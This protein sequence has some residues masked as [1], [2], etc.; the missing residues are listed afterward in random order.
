MQ[1]KYLLVV[2]NPPVP[3][4]ERE[5][6]GASSS[7]W[8]AI[9]RCLICCQDKPRFAT[10]GKCGHI[11]VCWICTV[12]LRALLKDNSCPVCKEE[13]SQVALVA[14][15]REASGAHTSSALMDP[16]LGIIYDNEEIRWE[17]ERLF[18]YIC[19]MH[20][21]GQLARSF[22][23]LKELERHLLEEH[24]RQF[25]PT[26]LR[27]RQVF[28]HEQLLYVSDDLSR[29][30][31]EGDAAVL[32]GGVLPPS[33]AHADCKFCRKSIYSQEDLL[34]HMYR[35]H[36]LC[37]LCE[38]SGR[39]WEFYND[40]G[41][42]SLHYQESHYVCPHEDCKRG[43]HYLVAYCTEEELRMH[44][45]SEHCAVDA[46]PGTKG[47]KQGLRLTLQFG[48]SSYRDEQ[49]RRRPAG[50]SAPS[51]AR[52]D[53]DAV[54]IHFRRPQGQVPKG[55]SG[56]WDDWSAVLGAGS[57]DKEDRD[58]DRYP[59]RPLPKAR[60]RV[61][62]PRRSPQEL[63]SGRQKGQA[64]SSSSTAP[65]PRSEP[66]PPCPDSPAVL[67]ER[68]LAQLL[69]VALGHI[70]R[71][72]IDSA[73]ALDQAEYRERNRRF[74][75]DLQE[76]LG[77][78]QLTVFK[79]SSGA[80]RQSL[81]ASGS[82]KEGDYAV[83]T[84]AKQVLEVFATASGAVGEEAAGRLL[85]DLVLLLPDKGP[86]HLIYAALQKLKERKE[87]YITSETRKRASTA[88]QPS[89]I[90]RT[91]S[92]SSVSRTDESLGSCSPN[93]TSA[94][95]TEAVE[96]IP[97][98]A[99]FRRSQGGAEPQLSFLQALNAVLAAVSDGREDRPPASV[100]GSILAAKVREL[101]QIQAESLQQIH[102][103]FADAGG[104]KLDLEPMERLLALR[105]MLALKLQA[106]AQ[107]KS[108]QG[109]HPPERSWREWKVAASAAISALGT[110]ERRCVQTYV[111]F[112]L[113][114]IAEGAVQK[115]A[116]VR[117]ASGAWTTD[118]GPGSVPEAFDFPA[119][120][121]APPPPVTSPVASSIPEAKRK[122]RGRQVLQAWG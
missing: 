23:T 41:S 100:K 24:G 1:M 118:R 4:C 70:G 63:Q 28:L 87:A 122:G 39:K 97:C 6:L 106:K 5:A 40:Y 27:G 16:K 22:R 29:H 80:F 15:P 50:G 90:T 85:C 26:C 103:H 36:S 77:E 47:K 110:E 102:Q 68:A 104:D 30:H 43:V 33:A 54:H 107:P 38:R 89:Q 71:A 88:G 108:P 46:K 21:C 34:E 119:L 93:S 14:D 84:Y 56:A 53:A 91:R 72:G 109:H 10:R 2:R 95:L 17:V 101:D 11:E 98:A 25:C 35:Q 73:P 61:A 3:F 105:P 121:A 48:T 55:P 117:P 111:R 51:A 44:H 45:L 81:A 66:E 92:P 67:A 52:A 96:A 115:T 120:P 20:G 12:R 74:R 57:Q 58:E 69:A 114:H 13:L 59:A 49:D 86:R 64:A 83:R 79:E 112:C 62:A 9:D 32:D 76:S 78:S 42:L 116:P 65:A 8:H 37:G 31:R 60:P 99:A 18:D 113:R 19:W 75:V 7:G 94:T 82:A